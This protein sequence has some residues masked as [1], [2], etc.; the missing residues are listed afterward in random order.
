MATVVVMVTAVGVG[1]CMGLIYGMAIPVGRVLLKSELPRK[2]V[3]GL[4]NDA[5][6]VIEKEMNFA[7]TS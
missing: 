3:T 5:A 2:S 4:F 7:K 6:Y 1:T